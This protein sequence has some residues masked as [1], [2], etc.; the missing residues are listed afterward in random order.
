MRPANLTTKI[1]LDS[2]DPAETRRILE[3]LGFLDGQTTNPSLVAK[4][5]D[6]L[7]RLARGERFT[8][9]QA[10]AFYREVVREISAC[11]PEGSVSVE[12]DAHRG[13]T[14][15]ELFHEGERCFTWIP[16]AHVKF[17]T[18][19]A[20]LAAAEKGVPRGMRVN[21]TLCFSQP[22]AAAVHA[23]TRGG[24]RGDVFVSPFVGRLDDRG[25]D[26]MALV[27]NI[28]AMYR[29]AGSHVQVLT[30]SVR[31]IEQLL[32]AIAIG[33]DIVTVPFKVLVEWAKQG[34]PVPDI[35]VASTMLGATMGTTFTPPYQELDCTRP[36]ESFDLHH[37]L[38]AQ[39]LERFHADWESLIA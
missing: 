39:G 33:S 3:L 19:A 21:M 14:A 16:N 35:A 36:W 30:A 10:L 25:V 11:I 4:H 32:R 6:A 31:S 12:V 2:G 27:Q 29:A 7:V 15:D 22:Q 38:T 20:G 8:R 24:A 37:D 18:T 13:S 28:L 9:E 1:F 17:P 26:G 34:M 23:A 5:P